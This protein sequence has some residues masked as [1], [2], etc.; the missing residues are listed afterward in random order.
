MGKIMFSVPLQ[1]P[2]LQSQVVLRPFQIRNSTQ[3]H[4]INPIIYAH[5]A[6]L[7]LKTYGSSEYSVVLSS[8]DTW[9][10]GESVSG[11]GRM[12]RHE[13]APIGEGGKCYWRRGMTWSFRFSNSFLVSR[14]GRCSLLRF[15]KRLKA[16]RI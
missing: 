14:V 1:E 9:N 16:W 7:E 10:G 8:L 2:A 13:R 3:K 11:L 4:G 5:S 6:M 15:A 12:T